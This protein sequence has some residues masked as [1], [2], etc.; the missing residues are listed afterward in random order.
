M[1]SAV[2]G[3]LVLSLNIAQMPL[4]GFGEIPIW[5]LQNAIASLAGNRQLASNYHSDHLCSLV[6][7][8]LRV[9]ILGTFTAAS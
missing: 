3:S 5:V 6:S 9:K 2:T 8:P 4:F 1:A 7:M